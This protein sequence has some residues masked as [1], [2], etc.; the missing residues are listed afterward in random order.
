MKRTKAQRIVEQA[1]ALEVRGTTWVQIE[2]RPTT[3]RYRKFT[4]LERSAINWLLCVPDSNTH[5]YGMSPEACFDSAR[6]HCEEIL[7]LPEA[8][9]RRIK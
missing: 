1:D 8:P 5:F 7:H 6:A 3:Y 9:L 2:G 4:L